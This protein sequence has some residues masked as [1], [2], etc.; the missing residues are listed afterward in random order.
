MKEQQNMKEMFQ[1]ALKTC[2]EHINLISEAELEKELNKPVQMLDITGKGHDL[3][4]TVY[5]I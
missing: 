1:N 2:P 3:K 4:G 5:K